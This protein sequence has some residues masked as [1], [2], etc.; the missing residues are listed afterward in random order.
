MFEALKNRQRKARET[1]A[2][3]AT[4]PAGRRPWPLAAVPR[5]RL[6]TA[7]AA[8]PIDRAG[9]WIAREFDQDMRAGRLGLWAPVAF[10]LGILGYFAVPQEPSL[11]A[12]GLLAATLAVG[13]FAARARGRAFVVTLALA[14][15]AAGF[16]AATW[17]TARVSA[18]MLQAERLVADITGYVVSAEP[19]R[20]GGT[21]L[22]IAVERIG[23]LKPADTPRRVSLTTRAKNAIRPGDPFAAKAV[24]H[25]PPGPAYPGGA[26]FRR[27]AYFE[28]RGATGYLLGRPKPPP[29]LAPPPL[30]IR[31]A[32]TLA[33]WRG[34]IAGRIRQAIAGPESEIA[35]A[36]ITGQRRGIPEAIVEDLRLS[37]LAHVLAISGLHMAL[38]AG[39]V[40]FA[41]RAALALSPQMALDRP[42]RK[43]AAAGAIAVG[44]AYLALSGAAVATERAFVM[45]AVFLFA[46]LVDRSV[47]TM[48]NVALAALVILVA[49][50]ESLTGPSFQMSFAAAAALIA[51]YEGLRRRK[52]K[53]FTAAGP[54]GQG[55]H[56]LSRYTGGL[57]LTSLIAGVAT[58]PFAAYHFHRV[59]SYGLIANLLA[60]PLVAG[61]VMPAAVLA[62]ALMPF[63]LE[64]V[65]LTAMQA[66]LAGVIWAADW[67]AH[68]PGAALA[69]PRVSIAAAA[70]VVAG[71][72]WLLLWRS[73]LR[74][75]GLAPLVLGLGLPP[76]EGPDVLVSRS[77]ET[78]AIRQENGRLALLAK[79][80]E[81]FEAE[82]WLRA[83][84]DLR[85]PDEALLDPGRYCDRL[86]CIGRARNGKTVALALI[87]AAFEADCRRADVVVTALRAPPDCAASIVIDRDDLRRGGAHSIAWPD[88]A[89]V[90]RA[91]LARR[92]ETAFNGK[93]APGGDSRPS[94]ENSPGE[95]PAHSGDA[96]PRQQTAPGQETTG[97]GDAAPSEKATPGEDPTSGQDHPVTTAAT[98]AAAPI[99]RTAMPRLP[100]PWNGMSADS[101]N[102]RNTPAEE[103]ENHS[104]AGSSGKPDDP[105]TPDLDPDEE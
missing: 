73:R 32:A 67:T 12:T 96:A 14:L 5:W 89:T 45:L 82:E 46:I 59:A 17:R 28:G 33:R 18:P 90:S 2:A 75:L 98:P 38:V 57:L 61:I 105:D 97:N 70:L 51:V 47:L 91:D 35:V 92:Q 9:H 39:T 42:I 20:R 103:R 95:E 44:A 8:G 74:L 102:W 53:P 62:M 52:P 6:A 27:M 87:P 55:Y 77:G 93:K 76:P 34:A 11:I 79:K 81:K 54:I 3:A 68:F 26:D 64:I 48:R 43:W 22:V 101:D 40:F 66:G 80:P 49:A 30:D 104:G 23:R 86:G 25:P 58:A 99:I 56:F 94:G 16:V 72:V 10:G 85:D 100:R 69:V 65:G 1:G 84:G 63:G 78:V 37:G 4:L 88:V 41:L 29:E 36:L 15:V 83:D 13:V 19:A 21:R 31:F 7:R 50:P 71:L 60:M 24:L